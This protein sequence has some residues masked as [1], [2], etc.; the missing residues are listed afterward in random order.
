MNT[1]ALNSILLSHP[2]TGRPFV[3]RATVSVPLE[4]GPPLDIRGRQGY[5]DQVRLLAVGST[6]ALVQVHV[7]VPAGTRIVELER[8]KPRQLAAGHSTGIDRD[9][10]AFVRSP[11]ITVHV[12]GQ[13]SAGAL[14]TLR[15][16]EPWMLGALRVGYQGVAHAGDFGAFRWWA[17]VQAG[18]QR[19]HLRLRWTNSLH[20]DGSARAEFLFRSVSLSGVP[21]GSVWFSTMP[22]P[23]VG[24]GFL[25]EPDDHVFPQRRVRDYDL[26]FQ[27][28]GLA[29]NG[30]GWGVSD[31]TR[32]GWLAGAHAL[33]DLSHVPSLDQ[34]VRDRRGRARSYLSACQNL[35]EWGNP[36]TPPTSPQWPVY[37]TPYPGA[38][39]GTEVEQLPGVAN[40]S[41]PDLAGRELADIDYLRDVARAQLT[42]EGDLQPLRIEAH[43]TA[44]GGLPFRM[45]DSLFE[46]DKNA[47][48]PGPMD[49]P[50]GWGKLPRPVGPRAYD[51]DQFPPND[52][53]HLTRLT[54]GAKVRFWL[55]GAPDAAEFLVAMAEQARATYWFGSGKGHRMDAPPPAGAGV[56]WGRGEWWALDVQN[57]ASQICNA[58]KFSS[59]LGTRV[60]GFFYW[61]EALTAAMHRGMMPSGL[62]A[63]LTGGKVVT[64]PPL[65]G[66]FTAHRTNELTYALVALAGAAE[67]HGLDVSRLV[68]GAAR[69]VRDLC[70]RP[71]HGDCLDRHPL[72]VLGGQFY[73]SRADV[74]ADV[75]AAVAG[76]GFYAGDLCGMLELEAEFREWAGGGTLQDALARLE[77]AG[78]T[79]RGSP[80]ECWATG[81][82]LFQERAREV[83]AAPVA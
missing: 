44:T 6:R 73:A 35:P 66:R 51:P 49:A 33:P 76:D 64:D 53:Q 67:S 27:R 61:A 17:W 14:A 15:D 19:A 31:W 3:A 28:E 75:L 68:E 78:L 16:G 60:E 5:V 82:A 41:T 11:M 58:H 9:V 83:P 29:D 59:Q 63:A 54:N 62:H 56:P 69:G 50:F 30:D 37:G 38:T 32:G 24:R 34:T 48:P 20:A 55:D 10:L 46:W 74:P 2:P 39:S 80:V 36:P 70:W 71:G 8:G 45:F 13:G 26:V 77:A 79:W 25:V 42:L 47:T 52:G 23:A 40:A 4:G 72:G 12:V 57:H 7:G 43:L 1:P 65:S 81:L 21:A 22:D 18:E